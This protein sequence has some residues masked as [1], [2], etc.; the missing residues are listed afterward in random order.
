[1]SADKVL[2]NCRVE[3]IQYNCLGSGTWELFLPA[4]VMRIGLY[5]PY[6]N[7]ISIVLPNTG[8]APLIPVPGQT[9]GYAYGLSAPFF[10]VQQD[11]ALT[12]TDWWMFGNLGDMVVYTQ[13]LL[14]KSFCEEKQ[15]EVQGITWTTNLAQQAVGGT[16]VGHSLPPPD[17]SHTAI[18]GGFSKAL[19][20]AAT[21]GTVPALQ[22][23]SPGP[24]LASQL[25]AQQQQA[26]YDAQQKRAQNSLT[27]YQQ[28]SNTSAQ[29]AAEA[30][31][32]ASFGQKPPY[33]P[34]L[35]N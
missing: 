3:T 15:E 11:G 9:E 8:G 25:Q 31:Y 24:T 20:L 21:G 34:T 17:I 6:Q 23:R 12:S 32:Y 5:F 30:A 28:Q 1:M 27:Q 13:I 33:N 29:A 14:V 16:P 4:N 7:F 2:A 18:A 26:L 35:G 19:N 10:R 22:M